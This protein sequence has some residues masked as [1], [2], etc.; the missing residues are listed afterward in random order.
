[1]CNPKGQTRVWLMYFFGT[2][3]EYYIL[4]NKTSGNRMQSPREKLVEKRG[5]A[6]FFKTDF[7]VSGYRMKG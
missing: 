6:E 4:P 7:E 5:A 2:K 1:M 3:K